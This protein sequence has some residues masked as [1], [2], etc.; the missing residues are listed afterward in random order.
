MNKRQRFKL[1]VLQNLAD[2]GLSLDEI[3]ICVKAAADRLEK[4]AAGFDI[5]SLIAKGLGTVGGGLFGVGQSVGKGLGLAGLGAALAAPPLLGAGVGALGAKLTAADDMDVDEAKTL[6]L[7]DRYKQLARQAKINAE[8]KK[9]KQGERP[10]F[11][12]F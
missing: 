7:I 12:R 5:G 4:Q 1:A 8:M 10:R 3:G 11:S 9:R 2:Q 6:E